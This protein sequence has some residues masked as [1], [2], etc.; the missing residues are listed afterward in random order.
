MT[1]VVVCGVAGRMG[2]R[3]AHLT[4][5]DEQLKLAGGTESPAHPTVGTDVGTTIG[6][7]SLGLT[8]TSELSSILRKDQVAIA[9]TAPEATLADAAVCAEKG[10]AMV[11]GTTGLT[12][13][14]AGRVQEHRSRY[15]VRFCTQLQHRHERAVQAGGGCGAHSR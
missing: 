7:S 11:V 5:A 13:D 3:L 9:F 8:V 15:T 6:A 4:L 14:P 10:A 12:E 1:E 2:Q